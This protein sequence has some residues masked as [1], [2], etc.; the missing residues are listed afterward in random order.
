[1]TYSHLFHALYRVRRMAQTDER[2]A[3]DT[4][5]CVLWALARQEGRA[6]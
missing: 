5:A 6:G 1:M 2:A 4:L 3:I